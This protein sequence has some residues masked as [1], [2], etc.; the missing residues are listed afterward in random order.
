V[1]AATVTQGDTSSG[2]GP[3]PVEIAVDVP[4]VQTVPTVRSAASRAGS[5]QVG[6]VRPVGAGCARR[7]LGSGG[8]GCG[9]VL[10]GERDGRPR[11][12][13][14][15]GREWVD[16]REWVGVGAGARRGPVRAGGSRL[17]PVRSRPTGC[18]PSRRR[19]MPRPARERLPVARP[20]AYAGRPQPAGDARNAEVD[21]LP[22][23]V[24]DVDP[25]PG[26]DHESGEGGER[27]LLRLHRFPKAG[28][29]RP[30][31][32]PGTRRD[33][34]QRRTRTARSCGG[35]RASNGP[36]WTPRAPI[37]DHPCHARRRGKPEDRH[38]DPDAGG[39]LTGRFLGS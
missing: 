22:V 9:R 30:P 25:S 2:S 8:A 28:G 35:E 5:G 19:D 11:R 6:A 17:V 16:G 36:R 1:P 32:L 34:D 15:G 33:R 20:R 27:P 31:D 38:P 4:M 37:G 18:R 14:A 13:G 10:R 12:R 29:V 23:R 24:H 3:E 26:L 39:M 7:C 21:D